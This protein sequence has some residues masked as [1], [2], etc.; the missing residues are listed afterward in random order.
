M[1]ESDAEKKY[2][3]A[4]QLIADKNYQEAYRLLLGLEATEIPSIP[5]G[6]VDLQMGIC[7]RH[8]G[9]Y[10]LQIAEKGMNSLLSARRVISPESRGFEFLQTLDMLGTICWILNR[11][12]DARH[13]YEEAFHYIGWYQR[14]DYRVEEYRYYVR[15][16]EVCL[17]LSDYRETQRILNCATQIVNDLPNPQEYSSD[18][19]YR[20]GRALY[21]E[22]RLD[23]ALQELEKVDPTHLDIKSL[24]SYYW[25]LLRIMDDQAN[26]TE[27]FRIFGLLNDIGPEKSLHAN[28]LYYGGKALVNLGRL[29]EAKD[30]FSQALSHETRS[31]WLHEE[32]R[33]FLGTSSKSG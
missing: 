30:L 5:P 12:E 20:I 9:E 24:R 32:C 18:I 7:C 4:L 14:G 25:V 6:S 31:S 8:L 23:T 26:Y 11:L 10:D 19:R 33:K 29:T 16:A 28:A 1:I 2:T 27:A 21:N 15:F 17:Y 13:Y 22:G 3:T